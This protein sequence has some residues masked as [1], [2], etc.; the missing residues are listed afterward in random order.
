MIRNAA[1]SITED[2]DSSNLNNIPATRAAYFDDSY[3]VAPNF[4]GKEFY[5]NCETP[6]KQENVH[7]RTQENRDRMKSHNKR[8]PINEDHPENQT[9]GL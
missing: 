2:T 6:T 3:A 1:R 7:Q 8:M 5:T 4:A 9:P